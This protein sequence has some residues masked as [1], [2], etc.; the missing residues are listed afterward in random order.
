MG[1]T[2]G[3]PKTNNRGGMSS[4]TGQVTKITK[5]TILHKPIMLRQFT[6]LPGLII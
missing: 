1:I 5:G 6:I 3:I 2:Y 4:G